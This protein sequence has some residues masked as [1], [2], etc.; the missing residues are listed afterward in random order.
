M[1]EQNRPD[2][3]R[4]PEDIY[5]L[6]PENVFTHSRRTWRACCL[7][8]TI[9]AVVILLLAVGAGLLGPR[10]RLPQTAEQPVRGEASEDRREAFMD[11]GKTYFAVAQRAD[12]VSEQAFKEL[13][14]LAQGGGSIEDVHAVFRNAADA[15][16][17]ASEEFKALPVPPTLLSQSKVRQ[18]LDVM[19]EAYDARR[20]ACEIIIAWDGDINDRSVAESYGR[21]AER[22]NRLTLEGLRHLGA[23]AKD[24]GLTKEDAEKFL[25]AASLLKAREFRVDAIP[26]L[27]P[28]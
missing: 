23:A 26:L 12:K 5:K 13:D 24:N 22:I 2:Q 18:S 4:E 15:N 25:P 19:S 6:E 3:G 11:F 7:A 1:E 8:P 20:R 16:E 14:A 27:S 9:A 17:K 28:R 21:Q 10:P